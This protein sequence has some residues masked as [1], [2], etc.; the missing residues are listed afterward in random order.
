MWLL[1]CVVLSLSCGNAGADA[2]DDVYDLRYHARFLPEQGAVAVSIEVE[3]SSALLKLVDLKAPESTYREVDGDGEISRED[4]RLRWQVPAKGGTL[5][6]RVSVDH[7]RDGAYDA[8]M[9]S[10]WAIL[11]LDD[12]FP[13]ARTRAASKAHARTTLSFE[14]PDD[15]SFETPY[16]RNNEA[17]SV[18]TRGRRFDRPVGWMVAGDIGIRR[19]EAAGRHLV[20]AGPKDESIRRLD[21]L[22]FLRWTVPDLVRTMPTF[23]DHILIVVGAQEMWRGGLSAPNSLYLHPDRPLVSGNSTSPLLHELVHA[24]TTEPPADGDDWM[25]EGIAEY[26][27]LKTL[28]RSGGISEA[29]FEGSLEWLDDWAERDH[30]KLKDPSTGPDTA[31]AVL[32]FRALDEELADA[33]SD[34]DAVVGDL[35]DGDL[36]RK[37]LAELLERELDEPSEVLRDALDED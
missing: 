31:R 28:W 19:T 37:R 25:A 32:L 30:G 13:P 2:D 3:Q 8:R 6:Y 29:R 14:G 11:R 15:W 23:P 9:T 4:G 33:D 22:T 5:R 21:I 35:L 7:K 26:Y 16:G 10:Q 36:N 34:L 27:A 24:S 1:G 12:L 20:I 17:V 18:A